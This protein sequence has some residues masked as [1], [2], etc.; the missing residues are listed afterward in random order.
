MRFAG[1]V[2]VFVSIAV[3]DSGS[4]KGKEELEALARHHE[5]DLA[6]YVDLARRLGF[7]ADSVCQMG[8]EV[9]TEAAAV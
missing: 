7:P 4:F 3:V 1:L 8:I 9:V 5:E 6:K 2:F